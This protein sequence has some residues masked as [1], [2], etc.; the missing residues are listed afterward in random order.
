M[1]K[2]GPRRI[3]R[4]SIDFKLKAVQMTASNDCCGKP[5]RRM[6]GEMMRKILLSL[7]LLSAMGVSHAQKTRIDEAPMYGGMDRSAIP[8]L[9]AADDKLI[10]DTTQQWGSREKASLAFADQGFRFYARDQLDMAMRR[11]NQAWLL[12]PNNPHAYWGF[13]AVLH[14]QDRM[15]DAMSHYEK[16][17]S[18]NHYI[19][20]LYP[21]AGR[22]ISLCGVQ[23]KALSDEERQKLFTRADALYREAAE[24]DQNKGYVY[25]SWATVNYWRSDYAQ[26][27]RA[28][29]KAQEH[30][31]QLPP[32]FLSMLK[33]KMAEP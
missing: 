19:S 26:S 13:G 29:K 3:N 17:L 22:A 21:D 10:A 23:N 4:Y 7:M 27:W 5:S 14:D 28:V 18:F 16:A 8:E 11:F 31:A 12:D 9:K 24:K 30:G 20:G 25:V 33:T 6:K 32:R 1:G 2:P 15:C